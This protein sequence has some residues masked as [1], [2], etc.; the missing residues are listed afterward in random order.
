ME[1]FNVTSL[2]DLFSLITRFQPVE[3]TTV[4]LFSANQRVCAQDIFAAVDLPGFARSTMDGYAVKAESTYG[5]SETN[6]AYFTLKGN[7]EMGRAP[8][9]VIGPNEAASIPTGGMLPQGADAVV[10]IEQ[11][12]PIDGATI[13]IYRSVAPLTNVIDKC[14]DISSGT[15]VITRGTRL[16]PAHIGLL[17]AIGETEI[18]IFKQPIVGIISTGNEIVAPDKTPGP[19]M[20]RE[21]NGPALSACLSD[22]GCIPKYYGIVEDDK[23][24]LERACR[25]GLDECDCLLLSGG[26]SVG[27]RDLTVEILSCLSKTEILVH[28]I[29]VRPGKPTILA[30]SGGKPVWGLPGHPASALVVF[31][32]VVRPFLDRLSGIEKPDTKNISFYARITRNI[33][34]VLGR[35]DFI[36]VKLVQRKKEIWAEP[37]IGK[38]GLI[39]TMAQADALAVI[40]SECEGLCAGELV[41]IRL[42]N[43]LP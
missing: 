43:P 35:T 19:G 27:T 40:D 42:L 26:S 6:P 32:Q 34:S 8:E 22:A 39:R 29:P 28:G 41:E 9:I 12:S 31:S 16:L 21:I 23:E 10:E 33:G 36:R 38:S 5:A 18:K 1:F 20:V 25:K 24:A 30:D 13:E 17:S 7:V 11:A 14:E 37:V 4:Q 3:T 15:K 2:D